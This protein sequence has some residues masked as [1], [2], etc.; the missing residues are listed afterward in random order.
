MKPAVG[1]ELE[2][3]ATE[4]TESLSPP[5]SPVLSSISFRVQCLSA[6]PAVSRDF[7]SGRAK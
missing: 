2:Q 3:E 6:N 1:I 4:G 5:L 7:D